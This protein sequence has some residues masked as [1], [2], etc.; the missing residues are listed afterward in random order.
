MLAATWPRDEPLDERLLVIDPRAGSWCDARVR[1]LSRHLLAGDLLVVND[2]A[3]VPASL[4]AVTAL[5][6]PVE[7]R[8]AAHRGGNRWQAV[9][10]GAGDWR[11][12]T[13]HRAAPP[14]VA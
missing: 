8:L 9:L 3:T 14:R 2:A 6:R 12:R 11:T 1:D 10:L 4:R 13:E 7:L 5:G